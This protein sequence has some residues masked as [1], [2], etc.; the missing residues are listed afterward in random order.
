MEITSDFG[1]F[2]HLN[3]VMPKQEEKKIKR[4]KDKKTTAKSCND[5]GSFALLQCFLSRTQIGQNIHGR[6]HFQCW[7]VNT[8]HNAQ[9]HSKIN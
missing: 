3:R 2:I 6:F 4:Q 5:Q 9:S 1:D 7:D 8:L